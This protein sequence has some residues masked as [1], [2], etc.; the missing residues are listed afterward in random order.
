M[1]PHLN[2]ML[3]THLVSPHTGELLALVTTEVGKGLPLW[4]HQVEPTYI[5][6]GIKVTCDTSYPTTSMNIQVTIQLLVANS[7]EYSVRLM[8]AMTYGWFGVLEGLMDE[9]ICQ[10]RKS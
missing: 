5:R 1:Q 10:I 3:F 7:P 2:L 4:P 6:K 8:T 9:I